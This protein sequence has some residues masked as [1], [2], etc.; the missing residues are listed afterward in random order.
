MVLFVVF[1]VEHVDNVRRSES[2]GNVEKIYMNKEKAYEYALRKQLS[3]IDLVNL[4]MDKENNGG[5]I[6]LFLTDDDKTYQERL[7]Y[8]HSNF[9]KIFGK[10]RFT[11]QPS[12]VAIYVKEFDKFSDE[13]FE[14]DI[15]E[16]KELCE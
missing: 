14:N 16:I 5:N 7:C 1:S 13:S 3:Y 9:T 2:K 15:Q 6:L 12:S 10:P 11:S 4:A 8:F